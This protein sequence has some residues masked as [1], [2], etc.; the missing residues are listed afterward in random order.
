METGVAGKSCGAV[1]KMSRVP[2][3]VWVGR[4]LFQGFQHRAET[5]DTLRD[6]GIPGEHLSDTLEAVNHRRMVASSE[7][8]PDL[9]E[10]E[11][12]ELADQI[13]RDLAWRGERLGP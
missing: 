12:E 2:T 7:G 6:C 9:D 8:R 13:H 4:S 1:G 10:L 3:R 5:R 11:P